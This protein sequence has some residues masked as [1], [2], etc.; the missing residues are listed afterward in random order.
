MSTT[1]ALPE[2]F[3]FTIPL[4]IRVEQKGGFSAQYTSFGL[5]TAPLYTADQLRAALA[6]QAEAHATE[7]AG[8]ESVRAEQAAGREY[9]SKQ[10]DALRAE[11]EEV[12]ER[13]SETIAVCEELRAQFNALVFVTEQ[14]LRDMQAQGLMIEWQTLLSEVIAAARTGGKA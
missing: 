13:R 11:L 12:R 6:A 2:P 10:A 5:Y 1:D 8:L 3:G 4:Y 14:V 9:W 7:L